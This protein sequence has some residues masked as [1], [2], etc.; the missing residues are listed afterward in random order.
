MNLATI[1]V[2]SFLVLGGMLHL[3]GVANA[4]RL[5]A[6]DSQ[7]SSGQNQ[8][9][10]STSETQTKPAQSSASTPVAPSSK[11]LAGPSK[12]PAKQV[13]RKEAIYPNCSNAPSA[14]NPSNYPNNSKRAPDASKPC[15]PPKKVV[16][17]GGSD[18]PKIELLGGTP[19]QQA[20][21]ERSTEQITAAT[22]ENLKKI[23]GRQ[24]SASEQDTVNQI[25]QFMDQSKQ[26]VASGDPERGRNLAM[27]ARLLSDELVKP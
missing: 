12:Q 2:S 17:N 13:H 16:R 4:F 7:A 23:N 24:L 14:L 5:Q 18:D 3:T 27:K 20:S 21:S 6:T 11:P 25:K 1:L 19:A 8:S 10:A 15:P 9:G 26:A 22:E